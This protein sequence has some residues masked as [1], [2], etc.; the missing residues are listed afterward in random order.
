[1]ECPNRVRFVLVLAFT[2]MLFG[3]R[4][5]DQH[6]E[7]SI[8]KDMWSF[9]YDSADVGLAKEWF[10]PSYD[11]SGWRTTTS[12]YWP[13]VNGDQ[14]EGIGWYASSFNVAD[15]SAPLSMYFGGIDDEGTIW[16]NGQR[17]G[18]HAQYDE[19]FVLDLH[20]LRWGGNSVVVRVVNRG[21]P[22][23][24]YEPVRLVKT[25]D[26]NKLIKSKFA[27]ENARES[28]EWVRNGAAKF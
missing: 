2:T 25:S 21:G 5:A 17:Y 9:S 28:A 26:V 10:S 11:R 27:D 13:E 22:G 3:C 7:S 6:R 19:P 12:G 20:G 15:S 8:E 23:G 24:L 16:I 1:M 18:T 4:S 14:V